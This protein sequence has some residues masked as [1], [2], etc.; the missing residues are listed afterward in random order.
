VNRAREVTCQHPTGNHRERRLSNNS[1]F[2]NQVSVFGLNLEERVR[3]FV[4][5][6]VPEDEEIPAQRH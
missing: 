4:E 1:V 3:Y 2:K 6:M 5:R